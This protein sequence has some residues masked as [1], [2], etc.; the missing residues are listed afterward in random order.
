MKILLIPAGEIDE[1]DRLSPKNTL[2]RCMTGLRLWKSGEYDRIIVSGGLFMPHSIQTSSA[3]H[4]MK[5]WLIK[6]GV[7]RN[8]IIVEGLSV[9]TFTN[10]QNSV[11]IIKLLKMDKCVIV[12]VT[13]WQ[14]AIRFWITFRAYGIK[15]K[16]KALFYHVSF[17]IFIQECGYII[18]HLMHPKGNGKW[19]KRLR[20]ERIRSRAM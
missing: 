2:I 6:H 12:V 14:H 5:E 15:I 19:A 10:T 8:L 17:K 13:Q 18:Y 1:L 9:D 11:A 7:N 20:E 4:L 3:A 16:L